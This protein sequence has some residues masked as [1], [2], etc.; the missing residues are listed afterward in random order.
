MLCTC[1]HIFFKL[2]GS[3]SK[4]HLSIQH[5][6]ISGDTTVRADKTKR[7]VII[8]WALTKLCIP[9]FKILSVTFLVIIIADLYSMAVMDK[10]GLVISL[11]LGKYTIINN[12]TEL[13]FTH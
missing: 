2:K 10:T 4:S 6:H 9:V 8:P 12:P 1:L 13:L 3:H 7:V 5:K 11:L